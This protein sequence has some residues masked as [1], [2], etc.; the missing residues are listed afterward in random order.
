MRQCAMWSELFPPANLKMPPT[1]KSPPQTT[2]SPD[3]SV[4]KPLP[5]PVQVAPFHFAMNCGATFPDTYRSLPLVAIPRI[6]PGRPP[7][8]ES[9][10]VP[11]HFATFT[12]GTP[13][14]DEMNPPPAYSVVPLIASEV[15]YEPGGSVP[16]PSAD[17]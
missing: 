5:S 6:N 10:F 12:A 14:T 13:P 8:K 2:M 9:H 4:A 15:T 16:E 1:Y 7:P 17:Q 3:S 11:S